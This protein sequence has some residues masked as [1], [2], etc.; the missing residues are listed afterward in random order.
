MRA[1]RHVDLAG[2]GLFFDNDNLLC[3]VWEPY[4]TSTHLISLSLV[5]THPHPNFQSDPRYENVQVELVGKG[6]TPRGAQTNLRLR[7]RQSYYREG[8]A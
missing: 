7:D 1:I 3:K 8:R 6:F 4:K 2:R 5:R